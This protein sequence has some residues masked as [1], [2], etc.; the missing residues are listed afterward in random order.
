VLSA[1]HSKL[2]LVTN[3]GNVASR[4]SC[5]PSS[6]KIFATSVEDM[7]GF[8][9]ARAHKGRLSPRCVRQAERLQALSKTQQ[10]FLIKII[11]VLEASNTTKH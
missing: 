6:Q 4:C 7:I 1:Y 10:R 9:P 5:S 11:D 2:Y 3:L 8:T